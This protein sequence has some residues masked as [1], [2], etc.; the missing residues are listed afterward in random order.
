MCNG[1]D[2][3]LIQL[4]NLYNKGVGKKNDM[5]FNMLK[6]KKL[7]PMNIINRKQ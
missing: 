4:F 2:E 6:A 7:G 3:Y 5:T 1:H